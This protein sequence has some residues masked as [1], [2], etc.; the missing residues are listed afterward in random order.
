[1]GAKA[2]QGTDMTE[3]ELKQKL[4]EWLYMSTNVQMKYRPMF[5]DQLIALFREAGWK[6]PEEIPNAV[7]CPYC[8]KMHWIKGEPK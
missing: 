1:M 4:Q 5:A 6:S 3:E 8:E 2:P 7:I